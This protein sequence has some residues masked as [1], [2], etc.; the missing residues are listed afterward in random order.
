[1][2]VILFFF[3]PVGEDKFLIILKCNGLSG[4]HLFKRVA[5]VSSR[6]IALTV[7][8]Q[9]VNTN[10]LFSSPLIILLINNNTTLTARFCSFPFQLNN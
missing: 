7:S 5:L 3:G 9:R 8:T 2:F 4:R 1:M 10:V 6:L